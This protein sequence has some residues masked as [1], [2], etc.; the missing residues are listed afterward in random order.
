MPMLYKHCFPQG[1]A[2]LISPTSLRILGPGVTKTAHK[3]HKWLLLEEVRHHLDLSV[4]APIQ[5]ALATGE[6]H[7][8]PQT[9]RVAEEP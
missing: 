6:V 8:L 9:Q 5:L 3:L 7:P 2:D 1:A 4:S